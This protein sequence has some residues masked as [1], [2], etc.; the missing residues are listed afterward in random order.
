MVTQNLRL[1]QSG[2]EPVM[3]DQLFEE[4]YLP[5]PLVQMARASR[6]RR[7]RVVITGISVLAPNGNTIEEFWKNTLAGVSGIAP[8][9]RFDPSPYPSRVAGEV[10]GFDP[11]D[12]M[13]F[14]EARRMARCSQFAIACAKMAAHDARLELPVEDRERVG[15]MVGTAVGGIDSTEEGLNTMFS[16]GWN[17]VSAFCHRRSHAEC[18][19]VFTSA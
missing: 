5:D 17:R 3:L 13:D 8:I 7:P 1:A 14:K 18:A 12:F 9:A 11:R 6:H 19:C 16:K 2:L 15:V 4:R 10:K